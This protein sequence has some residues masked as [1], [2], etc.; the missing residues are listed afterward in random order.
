MKITIVG[1]STFKKEMLDYQEKLEQLG[2]EV[3]VHPDYAAFVRGEKQEV[4]NLIQG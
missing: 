1:S 2:H 4:R 3:I